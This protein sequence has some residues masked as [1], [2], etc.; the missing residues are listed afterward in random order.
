MRIAMGIAMGIAAWFVVGVVV[1]R[2]YASMQ[3]DDF[4]RDYESHGA[5]AGF[6]VVCWPIPAIVVIFS[7]IGLLVSAGRDR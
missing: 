3:D 5:R 7:L 1:A 4:G 2:V 6:N